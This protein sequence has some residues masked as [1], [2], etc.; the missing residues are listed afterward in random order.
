MQGS[1]SSAIAIVAL[2]LMMAACT[3]AEMAETPAATDA[4]GA[5]GYQSLIGS[6]LAAVTLPA[7]LATRIIE[8]G[9]VVTTDYDAERLNVDLDA[10]GRITGVHCG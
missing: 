7:G 8:P 10:A 6:Q 1:G 4:C 2:A 9:Q 5:S 3:R